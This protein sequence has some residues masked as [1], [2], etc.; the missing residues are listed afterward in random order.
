[1]NWRPL[2]RIILFNLRKNSPKK[3]LHLQKDFG[4]IH[5]PMAKLALGL[6]Y[7]TLHRKTC[8]YL[9]MAPS[10]TPFCAQAMNRQIFFCSHF[11][12][13]RIGKG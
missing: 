9:H 7:A 11:F 2:S 8:D 6:G 1:M 12:I 13:N 5:A 4:Y 10:P 3:S